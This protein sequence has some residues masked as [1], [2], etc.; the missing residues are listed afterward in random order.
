M[1]WNYW[2]LGYVESEGE[3]KEIIRGLLYTITQSLR[4]DKRDLEMIYNALL[5]LDP[6]LATSLNTVI[7]DLEQII[8]SLIRI[9]GELM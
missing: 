2:A 7:Y 8:N 4:N 1:G 9:R 3:K 5:S 6:T